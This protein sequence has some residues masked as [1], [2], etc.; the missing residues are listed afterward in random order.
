MKKHM[1]GFVPVNYKLSGQILITI[2]LV[3][4]FAPL[5]FNI[6]KYF[7]YLGLGLIIISTYLL[8]TA[9]KKQNRE[10]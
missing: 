8:T 2:A 3:C 1:T 7:I 4:I 10:K 6:P 5:I 9:T